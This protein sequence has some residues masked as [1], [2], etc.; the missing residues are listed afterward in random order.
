MRQSYVD[1]GILRS[2]DTRE[3]ED[4]IALLCDV[5]ANMALR[6]IGE[7][8]ETEKAFFEAHLK[9][10]AGRFFTDLEAMR[11]RPFYAAVGA[12]GALFVTIE[13][14]AFSFDA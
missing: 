10:W 13:E 3:P 12:V 1:H 2:D 7:G 6:S 4:H 9:P 5:M 14:E 8:Y 11:T